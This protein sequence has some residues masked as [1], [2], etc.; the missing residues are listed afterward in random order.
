MQIWIKSVPITKPVFCF[1]RIVAKR[2]VF[3]LFRESRTNDMDII[4]YALPDHHGHDI[5]LDRF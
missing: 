1:N 5:I 3:S 2:G 4:E